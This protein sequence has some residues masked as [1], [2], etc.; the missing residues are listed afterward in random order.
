MTETLDRSVTQINK[1]SLFMKKNKLFL[2][3]SLITLTF[4]LGCGKSALFHTKDVRR[5]N[6]LRYSNQR[7][8]FIDPIESTQPTQSINPKTP[9]TQTTNT[10]VPSKSGSND[11]TQPVT[12]SITK[13]DPVTQQES[14]QVFQDFFPYRW[15]QKTFHQTFNEKNKTTLFFQAFDRHGLNIRD[16]QKDDLHL[17]ENQIEIRNYTLS[18]ERQRLDHKLEVVFVI[19]TAGS[20]GKYIDMIKNNIMYF[21]KKLGEDQI[22]TNLCFVTFRDLV[23]KI[24]QIFYPDNPH[25]SQNENTVKFL[26]DISNLKLHSGYNEYH[27]N[28]LGGLLAA[29]KHTPWTQGNQRMVILATD[30]LFWVPLYN[31]RPEARTSPNYDTVLNALREKNIQVFALTQSYHGFSSNYFEYPSLVEATSGQ[32]FNIKTLEDRNIQTVF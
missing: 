30:A 28:V 17:L 11:S 10:Y 31:A 29:A 19:D 9:P 23:E 24:C 21:V 3:L 2:L 4:H 12:P 32:W 13:T 25:T 15:I 1:P 22:Q 18:S 26:S 8:V 14:P 16:L 5:S 20:M 6:H 27:E 7:P